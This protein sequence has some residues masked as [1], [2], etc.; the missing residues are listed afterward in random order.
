MPTIIATPEPVYGRYLISINWAD[1]PAVT[2]ASVYRVEADGTSTPVRVTTAANSTGYEI[3][4]SGGQAVLYDTEAPLDVTLTYTT[5]STMDSSTATSIVDVLPSDGFWLKDPLRPWA[6]QRVYLSIPQEPDCVPASAIF[7][8]GM[9]TESRDARS[10]SFPV[11]Q[12][13]LPIWA[14]RVRGSISSSLILASRSFPDRDN[15]IELNASGNVLLFQGPAAYGIPDRY[16]GIGPYSISRLSPDHKV[17][18]RTHTMPHVQTGRP[19]GLA[20]GVLGVR[21]ADVCDVYATFGDI[22]A[23]NVTTTQVLYGAAS[24]PN[25]SAVSGFRTY[26][27]ETAEFATYSVV[28]AGG[29]TYQE[30]YQGETC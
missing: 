3:E 12:A 28:I 7:F 30:M 11:N 10:G 18:W 20:E 22:T 23:A 14:S 9:D 5:Q 24:L 13:E 29:C 16:M 25:S 26:A 1:K 6:D 15:L 19:A 21:W 27:D 8:V 4:L 17:P 2:H